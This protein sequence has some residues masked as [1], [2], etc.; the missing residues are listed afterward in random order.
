[1]TIQVPAVGTR[2]R[3]VTDWTKYFSVGASNLQTGF[4]HEGLILASEENDPEGTFRLHAPQNYN[5]PRKIIELGRVTE[6]TILAEPQPQSEEEPST[7]W[8]CHTVEGSKGNIYNVIQ[9]DD[10]FTCDCIAGARGRK[11][12]HVAEVRLRLRPRG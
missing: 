1:M 3:V 11:C 5:H 10:A 12:K 6:L 4:V 7:V 2:V 9:E 8:V